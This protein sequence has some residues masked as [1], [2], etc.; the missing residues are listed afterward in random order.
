MWRK[1]LATDKEGGFLNLAERETNFNEYEVEF[2]SEI[3]R[4]GYIRL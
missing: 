3:S 1:P 4:Q 2:L